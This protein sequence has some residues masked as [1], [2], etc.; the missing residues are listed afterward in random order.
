MEEKSDFYGKGLHKVGGDFT[1]KLMQK[2][3]KE[4]IA[5]SNILQEHGMV[6]TSADFTTQL[7]TQ[8]DNK[9]VR[10]KYS[11]VISLRAWIVISAVFL[12]VIGLIIY[13]TPTEQTGDYSD[14]VNG[15]I[16][17]VS[18]FIQSF[19]SMSYIFVTILLFSF[20]LLFEQRLG[21][22]DV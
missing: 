11:P 13:S 21:K 15:M 6:K 9:R 3:D 17:V 14:Y 18:G 16:N 4:E 22:R 20:G 2:I 8:L 10:V 7:L 5:L 12:G 19:T 1:S